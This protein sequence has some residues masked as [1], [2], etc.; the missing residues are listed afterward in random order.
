MSLM[1]KLLSVATAFLA[2]VVWTVGPLATSAEAAPK[3][4]KSAVRNAPVPAM[5]FN[6]A[7]KLHNGYLPGLKFGYVKVGTIV[8]GQLS[9]DGRAEA[10]AVL[11]CSAG[12]APFPDVI[13]IYGGDKHGRAVLKG[14]TRL[15]KHSRLPGWVHHLSIS[16]KRVS[17]S[18][19][20]ATAHECTACSTVSTTAR[21]RVVH[22]KVK[23]D[24]IRRYSAADAARMLRTALNNRDHRTVVSMSSPKSLGAEFEKFRSKHGK[25]TF[26]GCGRDQIDLRT[27]E[28]VY[29]QDNHWTAVYLRNSGWRDWKLI[30][31]DL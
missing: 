9:G 1:R 20:D 16:K 21:I 25:F 11:E 30:G 6:K 26:D 28:C 14:Y 29:N 15:E 10:A 5:C 18:W 3:L 22:G 24:Q 8:F 4:T 23:I 19:Y 7:G 13:A 31:Y 12:N 2:V 27:Y 17:A